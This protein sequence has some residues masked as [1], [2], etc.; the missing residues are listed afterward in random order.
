MKFEQNG[1]SYN[2]KRMYYN[3]DYVS[4]KKYLG[5]INWTT[6]LNLLNTQ[7]SWDLFNKTVDFAIDKFIPLCD[8]PRTGKQWCNANVKAKSKDKRNSWSKL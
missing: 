3:G 8:K 1:S 6:E 7:Q 2:S 4:I 5:D